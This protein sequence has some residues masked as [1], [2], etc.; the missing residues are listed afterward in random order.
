MFGII[1]G[2]GDPIVFNRTSYNMILP[3]ITNDADHLFLV[4]ADVRR[5]CDK[6]KLQSLVLNESPWTN[7]SFA[8]PSM[9]KN[10]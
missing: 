6:I 8:C 4:R 3:E 9:K 5:L 10:P 7:D 1:S 2:N